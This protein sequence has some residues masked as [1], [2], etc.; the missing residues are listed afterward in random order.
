MVAGSTCFSADGSA[1]KACMGAINVHVCS[2]RRL[3]PTS[4]YG[5]ESHALRSDGMG[6][7]SIFLLR[8]SRWICLR[9]SL[10]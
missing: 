3:S 4:P 8:K 1:L 10:K 2:Q 5:Q 9:V 6:I 7:N